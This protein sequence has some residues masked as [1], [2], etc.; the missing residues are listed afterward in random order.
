MA[1]LGGGDGRGGHGGAGVKTEFAFLRW[2]ASS[3][4]AKL[5]GSDGGA[6]V[7]RLLLLRA[8]EVKEEG[9]VSRQAGER[10]FKWRTPTAASGQPR[11]MA[12]AVKRP[13]TRVTHAAGVF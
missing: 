7:L 10:G 4:T 6:A 1:Q 9:R 13:A 2:F 11:R 3:A 12:C 5:R 8:G